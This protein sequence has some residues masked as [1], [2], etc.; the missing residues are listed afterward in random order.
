MKKKSDKSNLI[1]SIAFVLFLL[2]LSVSATY[3]FFTR[4]VEATGE[5][6]VGQVITGVLDIDFETNEYIYNKDTHLINDS[7]RFEKADKTTFSIQRS[8]DSTVDNVSYDL[9]LDIIEL[10][11][12]LKSKYVKWE[13]YDT[14]NPNNNLKPISEGNFDNIGDIKEIKLN[15]ARIDLKK[16]DNHK[17]TLYMWLSYSD[18]ELQNAFLQKE[19]QVKVT[20]KAYTY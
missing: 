1:I 18:T 19:L 20:A 15:S 13:L 4:R 16:T 10:P 14:D 5:K 7:E 12:E 6:T 11:N 3:A 8:S 17:Y 2:L 9:Y